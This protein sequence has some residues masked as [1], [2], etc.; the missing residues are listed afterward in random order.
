MCQTCYVALLSKRPRQPINS[1]ANFQ[2]YGHERL[3]DDIHDAFGGASSY[4]LMLI[5]RARASQITHFYAYKPSMAQHC[6]VEEISQQYNQGNVAVRPQNSTELRAVLPPSHDVLRD[7]MCVVFTGQKQ[8]PSRETIKQMQPVLVTKSRVHRLIE[9]LI[10]NNPWY[11]KS[12]VAYSQQNM[13]A[14]FDDVDLD[15]DCSVPTALEICHLPQDSEIALNHE[16]NNITPGDIVME[17]VGFTQGDHSSQSREK[18]KL[19]AL[20]Y[21][22]DQKCFLLSWTGADFVADNDPGL[23]PYLFPQLDPWDIGGFYHL[24]VSQQE[25]LARELKDI[26]PSLTALAEKWM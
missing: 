8:C 2:Y 14:L 9:F 25:S 4:D 7:A 19:H 6:A 24:P 5:S 22:L 21:V 11:Q 26:G 15:I 23:M 12:G 3:P 1:L 18:M 17:A 13:D 10:D 20:A 16:A